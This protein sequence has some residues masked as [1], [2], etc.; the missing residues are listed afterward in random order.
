MRFSFAGRP[1]GLT[2]PGNYRVTCLAAQ[3]Q[4]CQTS[5]PPIRRTASSNLDRSKSICYPAGKSDLGI[6]MDLKAAVI[7]ATKSRP[8]E[9]SN[10]IDTLALQTSPPDMIIVSACDR[11]DIADAPNNVDLIFGPPGSSAQR[12][13]ALSLVRG[14]VDI[15]IFFDDDFIPSR[16]WIENL[17]ALLAARPEVVCV[18]GRVLLDGVTIGGIAWPDGQSIVSKA[19]LSRQTTIANGYMVKTRQSP[20]GCNMAFRADSIGHLAFDERLVLYGWMED[21]D[22]AFRAGPNR[23]WTDALWGVHLGSKRGRASGLRFGYSQIVNPWYLMKKGTMKPFDIFLAT[24][25]ALAG[26]V[27][28]SLLP[29]A[30]IDRRGRLRGNMIAITDIISG[31]WAPE[32]AAEL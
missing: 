11:S 17:K 26:N 14:K 16:Y 3:P 29:N 4:D 23:V 32:R 24:F 22:F 12:N 19:D 2:T 25:R 1:I 21:C 28:G 31:R 15:V 6:L 27:S 7:I 30:Q 20:Y 8:Q 18:T 9:V 13:R 5:G 10:L